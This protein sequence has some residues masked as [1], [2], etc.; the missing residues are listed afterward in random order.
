M[1][2]RLLSYILG[3]VA[4]VEAV[5]MCLPFILSMALKENTL[6]A[7]GVTILILL[8]LGAPFIIK[9][10]DSLDLTAKEG[11]VAVALSWILLSLFGSL[12][13]F[14]S[15]SLP[16]FVDSLFESASGFTTTGG[17]VFDDVEVLPKSL[18]LWRSFTNWIGGMG[19]LVFIIA[20]IPKSNARIIHLF[21]AESPGP[22]VGKLVSKLKFTARILYAIYIVL[23][24]LEIILLLIGRMPLFD[25]VIHAF[26]T[27]GTGGFSNKNLSV[28]G[29]GSVYIDIVITIFMFLFAI[30]FNIYYLILIGS[31]KQALKSEELRAFLG[32]AALSVTII[33]AAL[34]IN[35]VYRSAHE[36]LRHTF[37]QVGSI[38]STTA[39]F[40][41]DFTAWPMAAQA[42]LFILM[43]IGACAGSTGGGLKVSR[44]VILVK[45]GIRE[46]K[47]TISPRTVNNLKFEGKKVDNETVGGVLSYFAIY[48]T[49]FFVSVILLSVSGAGSALKLGDSVMASASCLNNVGSGFGNIGVKGSY[50]MFNSFAKIVLIFDM[51]A[52]RLEILPMLLLFNPRTWTKK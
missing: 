1:R 7:F 20:I 40:T 15:G 11:F 47:K 24:L 25:S 19:A 28:G 35:S 44:A 52:G 17:T 3:Q 45:A 33:A 22:Q 43:F 50:A 16:N 23:T 51:L 42:V 27:A 26:G 36:I 34:A 21:K 10:P 2:Y 48:M 6:L 37:F 49:I 46:I 9:K 31:V 8:A 13:F 39:Y 30:N 12:P 38:M 29:Y 14:I 18:L 41:A 5:L 32:I 4:V